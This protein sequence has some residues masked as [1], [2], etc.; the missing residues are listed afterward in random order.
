MRRELIR[1]QGERTRYNGKQVAWLGKWIDPLGE[2][3][4]NI[5]DIA[6]SV[7]VAV[8]EQHRVKHFVSLNADTPGARDVWPVEEVGDGAETLW[9]ALG[10]DDAAASVHALK[11]GVVLRANVHCDVYGPF[12]AIGLLEQAAARELEA[13][14]G[15]CI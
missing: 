10:A 12:S 14:S 7:Q 3:S 11:S 8:A 13:V 2:M 4:A 15:D 6:R 1:C 5:A 9:F